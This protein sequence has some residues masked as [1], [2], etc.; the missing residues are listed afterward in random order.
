MIFSN[1]SHADRWTG[2]SS[3]R[4][5]TGRK[6]GRPGSRRIAL[7]R[8]EHLL[9]TAWASAPGAAPLGQRAGCWPNSSAP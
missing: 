6:L 2:P 1:S 5:R 9:E 3:R 7:R 8:L 4:L